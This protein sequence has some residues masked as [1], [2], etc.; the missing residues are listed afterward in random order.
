MWYL[1][2]SGTCAILD[3][4]MSIDALQADADLGSL[5]VC[6]EESDE[7]ASDEEGQV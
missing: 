3:I 2:K 5:E 6:E 4:T 7:A 1:D